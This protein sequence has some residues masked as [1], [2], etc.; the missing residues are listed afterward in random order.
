M[1]KEE[2]SLIQTLETM[3]KNI[4]LLQQRNTD[5]VEQNLTLKR[6]IE[7]LQEEEKRLSDQLLFHL[8]RDFDENNK[9]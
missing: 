3:F 8:K 5:L 7:Q 9:Q 2:V 4:R 6:R 1:Q